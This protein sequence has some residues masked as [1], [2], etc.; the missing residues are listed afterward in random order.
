M[1]GE[2]FKNL[3]EIKTAFP[4]EQTCI[5]YLEDLRW[6]G[7]VISPF[8]PLSKVYVCKDG[9]Y[10]CRNTGKY[11][12]VK[13]GTLF[14]NSKVELQ[15]WFMAIWV[16][17]NSKSPI[18]SVELGQQLDLTQKSA[19]YMLR[20]IKKNLGFD[21]APEMEPKKSPTVQ[22]S[23]EKAEAIEVVVEKEKLQ[24]HEWLQLLKK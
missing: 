5:R 15:K 17:S 23:F 14:Y 18:T 1:I 22:T 2:N 8:D 16:V 24:M 13:T 9:R 21:I 6:N 11:F 19:W 10:R 7:F 3:T 4:D 12:N 20:R